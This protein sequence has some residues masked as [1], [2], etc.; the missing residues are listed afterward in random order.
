MTP[1]EQQTREDL[2]ACYRLAALHRFT[3]LIYTHITA[4]IPGQEGHFLINPYGWRWEE[5]TA[6]SLVRIDTEG[7]K[8]DG[9]PHRVN[10]AGFTIHSALHMHRHDAAWIMHTH[11]R[12]G[13]ALSCLEE[14]LLPLNQ[15]SLQFHNRVAYHDFE[16]ISLDPEE[17]QRLVADMGD[18][19]VMVLRNHGLIATGRS[20][21][22]MFSN[23]F[24]LER[25]CEIQLAATASGRPLRLIED[26]IADRVHGQ[27]VQMNEEDGD[28]ALEWAAHLRSL[29]GLASDY[30]S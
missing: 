25:A 20:A 16:G 10:P 6:S 26:S 30:R 4:R 12:A 2:A 5:I 14:G 19:P 21:A 7:R 22:E 28:L 23:M 15:I 13:V 8:L 9:S 11:T 1:E 3:D 24:Y 17:R 18:H 27:Y 29:T